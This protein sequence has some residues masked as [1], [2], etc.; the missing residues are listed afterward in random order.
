MVYPGVKIVAVAAFPEWIKKNV[1]QVVKEET[2]SDRNDVFYAHFDDF[3]DGKVAYGHPT[4]ESHKKIADQ[5]IH[6]MDQL[7]IFSDKK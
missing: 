7:K 2:Q 5:I 6:A 1:Q 4:V 3:P